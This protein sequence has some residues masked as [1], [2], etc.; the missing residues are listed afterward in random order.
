VPVQDI[1]VGHRL[2]IP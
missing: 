2:R 1:T